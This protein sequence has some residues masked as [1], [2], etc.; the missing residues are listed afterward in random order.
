[1]NLKKI[2]LALSLFNFIIAYPQSYSLGWTG[3]DI[4]A[5]NRFLDKNSWITGTS[6]GESAFATTDTNSLNIHWKFGTGDRF[7]YVVCFQQL[8]NPISMSD[9]DMIGLDVKG[10]ACSIYRSF[11]LKFEDGTNQAIISW[12][13]LASLNRWCERLSFVKSQLVGTIDW[14]HILIVTLVIY[15]NASSNDMQADSGIVSVKNLRMENAARW[16]K[17]ERTEVLTRSAMLDSVK[18]KAIRGILSR[19]VSNGLF[20]TWKEDKSSWLYGHGLL[21]KIL[22]LEGIWQNSIPINDCARAA[23]KLA[24]FLINHQEPEGYWPRAW[25]TDDGSIKSMDITIWMGDLPWITTG[26]INYYAKSGDSRVLPA[27]KKARAFLYSLIQPSGQFYTLNIQTNASEPVTSDEAYCAA[28]NA[29]YELGD[30][31][32]AVSMYNYISDLSWDSTLDY[33]KEG[34]YSTRP[35][36]FGNTWMSLASHLTNDSVK[37]IEALSFAGKALYTRGPGRP[38]GMDGIGPV[39]TWYE[40]TLSYI[41]AGGPGSQ[42]IYDSIIQYRYSDGTMPAYNDTIGGKV[43]IWAVNWSSLDAT[44][45]LYYASAGKSPFKKYLYALVPTE[46]ETEKDNTVLS[47]YPVPAVN[48]IYF[49]FP[50]KSNSINRISIFDLEGR[51]IQTQFFLPGMNPENI[52]VSA[53]CNGIYFMFID[54]GLT[55]FC[56]K[57]EIL[58]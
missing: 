47:V 48:K 54:D 31:A 32:K 37:S 20:Y 27:L 28:I 50:S 25:N 10:S 55:R 35:V 52:D 42:A 15:S 5:S 49:S 57:I 7:K 34:V 14:N 12:D 1:M 39:A 36:L 9:S 29:V 30:S 23:E 43:D 46:T 4:I 16:Q 6:A 41:C 13:G 38:P 18:N 17:A 19:Q 53:L 33:W 3:K 24:F 2:L 51:Q 21:L 44:S 11:S 22:A 45:W 26:L 8:Q 56:R 58:H 40:G